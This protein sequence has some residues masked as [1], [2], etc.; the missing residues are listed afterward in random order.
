MINKRPRKIAF[1]GTSC[2]GKTTLLEY[3]RLKFA[4]SKV[5]FVEE[6][7]RVFFQKHPR[8][9]KRF[10]CRTQEMIQD[11]V[12]QA[13]KEA[14]LKEAEVILCDRSVIDPIAYVLA[15]GD[16]KGA[17]KLFKKVSE[18][19]VTYDKFFLLDPKDVVYCQDEVR[20]ESE[21]ERL[22]LHK[23]FLKLFKEKNIE[24]ELLSGTVEER[25]KKVEQLFLGK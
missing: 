13:E 9:R 4:N 25:A 11:L 7:A 3:L 6:S 19:L 18:W 22:K 20:Q 23:A 10:S 12:F 17:E 2:T 24:L 5:I 14:H 1:V 15:G 21:E 8:I 16:K